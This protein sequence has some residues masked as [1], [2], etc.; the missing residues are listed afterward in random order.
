MTH[1]LQVE[2]L[3]D[4]RVAVALLRS[5]QSFPEASGDLVPFSSPFGDAEREDIRWYLEDYLIAPTRFTKN[6]A[7][8]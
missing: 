1:R 3:L 4:G 5:G 2:E 8:A 7:A 6:A